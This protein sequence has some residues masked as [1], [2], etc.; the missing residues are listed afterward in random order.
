[1]NCIRDMKRWLC[2]VL[3]ALAITVSLP[4]VADGG[5]RDVSG[6]RWVDP[7]EYLELKQAFSK[8]ETSTKIVDGFEKKGTLDIQQII[9]EKG[10]KV[11]GL[12]LKPYTAAAHWLGFSTFADYSFKNKW[13]VAISGESFCIYPD[14]GVSRNYEV[15][16][17]FEKSK[18]GFVGTYNLN[19]HGSLKLTDLRVVPTEQGVA[20]SY[21]LD[22]TYKATG[23]YHGI[24]GETENLSFNKKSNKPASTTDELAFFHYWSKDGLLL[25]AVGGKETEEKYKNEEFWVEWPHVF[26]IVEEILVEDNSGVLS[27]IGIMNGLLQWLT[28]ESD[29]FGL[30]EHTGP[31][32]A[33]VVSVIGII[34]S[35][36][37]SNIGAAATT[38]PYVPDIPHIEATTPKRKEEEEKETSLNDSESNGLPEEYFSSINIRQ[39]PDG[40]VVMW[41]PVTGKDVHFYANGDGTWFSDSGQTYTAADIEERYRYESEN[42]GVL[43]Q[44]AETA[45]RNLAEQRAAWDAQNQRDAERGYSDEQKAYEDW[46]KAQETALNK[47]LY[48]DHMMIKY[49][50]FHPTEESV[51]EA[52]KFDQIMNEI[53]QQAAESVVGMY[54][55]RIGYLQKIDKRAEMF[56]NIT[57]GILPETSSAGQ[58]K[59]VY[60]FAKATMVATSEVF[61]EGKGGKEAARH[62]IVG[63]GNG[64]LGVLQNEASN[65]AKA[66][67]T[68]LAGEYI[69]T[70]S[71]EGLKE[72]GNTLYKES[73][74]EGGITL[75]VL[76][77]TNGAILNAVVRKSTE[78]GA[79][80]LITAGMDTIRGGAED[81]VDYANKGMFPDSGKAHT[82]MSNLNSFLNNKEQIGDLGEISTNGKIYEVVFLEGLNERGTYESVGNAVE[83]MT[84]ES[85]EIVVEFNEKAEQFRRR[86]LGS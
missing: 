82:M 18:S 60:T 47:E 78:F 70:I 76:A 34:A 13:G 11:L 46:K 61:A 65:I 58:I 5:K 86:R 17:T 79:T 51:R 80:K 31:L 45:A 26:Y 14:E 12:K 49:N 81:Y 53:D 50:A 67:G 22:C 52:M 21:A 84:N 15:D 8:L 40:D 10:V 35:I 83:T 20:F 33:A 36:L 4:A 69:V 77:K 2:A 24:L 55:D 32:E 57:A 38:P 54:D 72:G 7:V 71:T 29:P 27:L 66:D 25:L 3:V 62:I 30:G 42:V 85:I 19:I 56:I 74:K 75:D 16:Y 59:N 64:A 28:G 43:R 39:Q 68:G 1:M 23:A 63:I 48:L 6:T 37:L 73:M 9:R 41:S 44:D